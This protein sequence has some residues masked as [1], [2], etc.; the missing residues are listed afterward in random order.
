MLRS[1]SNFDAAVPTPDHFMPLLYLAGLANAAGSTAEVLVDGYTYGSLSMT[2][3][4]VDVC[5]PQELRPGA[6]AGA[7]PDPD[8]IPPDDTN[9]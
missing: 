9:T 1:H 4:T 6:V 2:S 8:L 7:L 3:Y 5:W